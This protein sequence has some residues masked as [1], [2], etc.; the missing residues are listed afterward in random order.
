MATF[1]KLPSGAWR[2]EVCV[3]RQ[4]R[5]FTG[6][7]KAEV[8]AIAARLTLDLGGSMEPTTM[9][10]EELI[11]IWLV[12]T[13]AK[14]SPTYRADVLTVIDKLPAAFTERK[15]QKVDAPVISALV[16]QLTAAGLSAHRVRRAHGIV[17]AA[18]TTAVRNGWAP[19]N[20]AL[21]AELP[22]A[23]PRDVHPPEVDEV[24][25][26]Y[27]D[28]AN[29]PFGLYLRLSANTGAR[30]GELVGLTWANVTGA[31]V[32]I[33][34]SL[35]Y[36]SASGVTIGATKTGTKGHR[37]LAIPAALA[38]MLETERLRQS[39]LAL[40]AGTGRPVWVFS[41]DAGVTPWRPDYPTLTFGRLRDRLS[42]KVRLH[43]LRHFAATQML[44]AGVPLTTVANRLGHSTT[45][46]TSRTYSHFLQAQDQEAAEVLGRITG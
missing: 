1:R 2:G 12:D 14:H 23:A 38:A 29:T 16:R 33:V 4:R 18:F 43:D 13:E 36:T 28:T 5:S 9:T 44:G 15:L 40:A 6:R 46:T 7:T 22:I 37:P 35:R 10:V 32:S 24:A 19:A 3:N 26:L 31:Q 8:K 17:S 39:E 20:P 21:Y 27:A 25:Q 41:H 42:V 30:R 11:A 45:S 34:Q